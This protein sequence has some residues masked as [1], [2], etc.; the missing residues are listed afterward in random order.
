MNCMKC[1]RETE[2]EQVFCQDCQV[3]MQKHPISTTVA[4]HLPSRNTE[5]DKL[6]DYDDEESDAA[7]ISQLKGIIRWLTATVAVLSILLCLVAL[8][9]IHLSNTPVP[10]STI[11]KNYSTIGTEQSP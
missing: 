10:E 11:G 3:E 4:I 5:P 1:G 9:L 7:V 6:P 8:M 2:D